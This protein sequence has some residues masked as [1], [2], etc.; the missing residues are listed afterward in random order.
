[1]ASA[2]NGDATALREM[3]KTRVMKPNKL[4]IPPG[5]EARY[6]TF[7]N[8]MRASINA[9]IFREYLQ[10]FHHTDEGMEIPKGA[11]IIRGS[12]K[13]YTSRAKLGNAA[14]KILWEQC[15]DGHVAQGTRRADP[16]LTLFRGCELM[17]NDN[18]DVK[19][20]IANGTCCNFEKAVLKPGK[21]VQKMKV[22]GRWV[23]A[24]DIDDVDHIVLRFDKSYH[25][26]FEGTFKL[27]PRERRF[28]VEYPIEGGLGGKKRVNVNLT[29]NHFPIIGN[30]ATT[31][32]KLQG[33]TMAN[34]I[35]AEWRDTENWAYVVLSRVKTLAG[36]FL[37]EALPE[38]FFVCAG[39]RVPLDDGTL[40]EYDFGNRIG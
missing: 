26:T 9:N 39:A 32:H 14:H 7:T 18:I 19:D 3:Q 33:K 16:F 28:L 17:V 2:R 4:I 34:L 5:L 29:L 21:N 35:I 25:P 10:S 12:A 1:M 37:L 24:V 27:K 40:A 20:G 30:F 22:H 31:G 23:Y 13:W 36:I 15:S 8:K 38:H 11:L 6:A